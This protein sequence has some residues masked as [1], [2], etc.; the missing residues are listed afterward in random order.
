M[1]YA[2]MDEESTVITV[3]SRNASSR[4][5]AIDVQDLGEVD[6][7]VFIDWF[8][9]KRYVAKQGYIDV[10][11]P[12]GGTI[13]VKGEKSSSYKGGFAIR[14]SDESEAQV[15]IP[16]DSAICIE[17]KGAFVYTEVFNT[18]QASA[19]L[20]KTKG[21]GTLLA[22][23]EETPES[24]F[25]G[26]V[27][28]GDKLAVYARKTAGE[29]VRRVA[30]QQ[31]VPNSYVRIQREGDNQFDVSV[32]RTPGGYWKE[33]VTG[34]HVELPNHVKVGMTARNGKAV[35]EDICIKYATE[36]VL[37]DDFK[38]GY[39]AMF[40]F[41]PEMN[42]KYTKAGLTVT[43]Q[44]GN[45]R[46]L[47]NAYDEDWTFKTEVCFQGSVERDYAGIISWQD[48]DT[49]VAAGRMYLEGSQVFFIG[50]ANAGKLVV[51]HTVPDINPDRR[52]TVQLQRI[53]TTYSAIYSY[54][55]K[56]WKQIGENV[57][58]NFCAERT[59]L[60][61]N[62]ENSAV[63]SYATFGN[64]IHDSISY[65]TPR[66][67]GMVL[68]QMSLMAETVKQPVYEIVSGDWSYADEGY[69]Q[70]SKRQ[71]Q[72]GISNKI[73]TDFKI[74][75]T[76]V[77]DEGKG[78]IG[79]EFAKN[80]HDSVIGDGYLLKL[81]TESK[82][83]LERNGEC[84]TTIS[85]SERFGKEV[86]LCV[87]NRNGVF[88]VFAGL[89]GEPI[90]VINDFERTSGY[91]AYMMEGVTGHINNSLAASYDAGFYLDAAYEKL[92]FTEQGMEKNWQHT[93]AFANPFGI[94]V[95]DFEAGVRVKIQQF[96]NPL[97]NPYVGL[98][99]CSPEGKFSKD[100][101]LALVVDSNYRLLL[102]NG[103][104]VL[105]SSQLEKGRNEIKLRIVMLGGVI[106]AYTDQMQEA[107]IIYERGAGNG[108]VV[109]V[110]AN[111]AAVTFEQM[112]LMDL[113]AELS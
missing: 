6:G 35:F 37:W 91:L 94:G 34:L 99:F 71:A 89:A 108:G 52:A 13:F 78:Y 41:T 102:K 44:N 1:A 81:D 101:A 23:A 85:V 86:R 93:H 33:V 67:P 47:T 73:Y 18:F 46:L 49:Y 17:G 107:A 63:F 11:L 7:T 83:S 42:L 20:K 31:I 8:T 75:G 15:T 14:Y 53:G 109:S 79:F 80:S 5:F 103:D 9:G 104:E 65:N 51:Y 25:V 84:L 10:D 66:T 64:A 76:Y 68:K 43:P 38:N 50:R 61:V 55:G 97:Q 95:T 27:V 3:A 26:A 2:R 29:K 48:E 32:T 60:V 82:L 105:A 110:C 92:K 96:G 87:E 106:T 28:S 39:S 36:S 90:L 16:K 74:D 69:I 19:L 59:G 72:L 98:Y 113:T 77:I 62:G 112:T 100:K 111:M 88:A 57:V 54:D 21:T 24:A 30:Y 12:A 40:D 22:L 58:A 70:T 4:V 56:T 45:C